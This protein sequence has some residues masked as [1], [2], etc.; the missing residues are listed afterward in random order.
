MSDDTIR[1]VTIGRIVRRRRRLLVLLVVVGAL[2][3]YGTSLLL[4]P[5]YTTSASVLLPGAWEE[6]ELLTQAE[7]A[8]TSVVVDRTAAALGWHG[9]SGEELREQLT[10][11][12]AD[13]NII[14]IDLRGLPSCRTAYFASAFWSSASS[15]SD[16]RPG[17]GRLNLVIAKRKTT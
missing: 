2:V 9:V 7:I 5:R 14:K 17:V 16:S 10:A 4:P 12:A 8:T 13:G 11:K 15:S 6:R 1:L 3:G